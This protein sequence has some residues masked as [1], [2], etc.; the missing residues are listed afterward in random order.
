MYN[1]LVV[2]MIII[3]IL[4]ILAVLVQRSKG[5]GFSSSVNANQFMGVQ[6]GTDFIEKTT[7]TLAGALF[8]L[9]LVVSVITKNQGPAEKKG[10]MD[11][12]DKTEAPAAPQQAAP[13]STP[14]PE[15]NPAPANAD[16]GN[17]NSNGTPK[18]K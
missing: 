2:I 4:L 11:N 16:P 13:Q 10:L 17:T 8:I 3:A 5:G 18:T 1:F 12:V 6:K 9:C 15:N 14:A 7:W